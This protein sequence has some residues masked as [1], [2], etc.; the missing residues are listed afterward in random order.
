[1]TKEQLLARLEETYNKGVYN[2]E[3]AHYDVEDLLLQ[4][5]NDKEVTESFR[6]SEFW[7]A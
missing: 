7:Y 6:R 2:P 4:F 1:M 3:A 5:I